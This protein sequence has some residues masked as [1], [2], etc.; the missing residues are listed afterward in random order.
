MPCDYDCEYYDN[1]W[2]C[3]DD[4]PY[5]KEEQEIEDQI[6]AYLEDGYTIEEACQILSELQHI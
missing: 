5:A 3:P 1:G 4:C 2:E 6:L